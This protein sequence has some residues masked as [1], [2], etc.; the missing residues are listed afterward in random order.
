M[1]SWHQR[2]DATRRLIEDE[3]AVEPG[4]LER[5]QPHDQA[6]ALS[7]SD[8]VVVMEKG[9]VV[10]TAKSADIFA[11]PEHAYTKKLMRATPRLGISLR[12]LLPEDERAIV[13]L[14]HLEGLTQTAVAQRLNLPVGTV[15]SHV[16][17][18]SGNLP[19]APTATTSP[20]LS[21]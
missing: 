5:A 7:I 9:R 2:G 15:K 16:H 10:E 18:I 21:R 19:T 6:E 12:D 11:N 3:C 8:R 4:S 20:G 1:Q 17:S 13:Q 14:Q